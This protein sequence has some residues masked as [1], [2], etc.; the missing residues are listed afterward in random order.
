MAQT[1]QLSERAEVAL[2]KLL[3]HCR[4]KEWAGYDPYDALNSRMLAALPV[5]DSRIPRLAL[6]Q[7]LKRS[8][9]NLRPLLRVPKT[10]NPK[11]L[12]L[13]LSSLLQVSSIDA[14]WQETIYWMINRLQELR[15]PGV[16]YCCWGYS[17][18]WQTRTI[19]VPASAPN[20]VCTTFVANA[21]LDAYE[22]GAS[23]SCV[24]MALSAGEYLLEQL[25][26]TGEKSVAG[27]AYPLPSRRAQVHNANFLASALLCR[28][29][30]HTGE[31][32]F[33][34]PALRVAR[35]SA[36]KQNTDGSWKYGEDPKAQWID[37]FHTGYNLCALRSIGKDLGTAEFESSVQR[38]FEFYRNHFFREDGATRY[39]HNRTYPIDIHCVAQSIVT[40]ATL[41]DLDSGNL[42][43]AHRVLDWALDHLYDQRGFFY[44]R[45]LRL[46]T[47]KTSYMR[48]SQAWM[49]Y[50]MTALLSESH[51]EKQITKVAPVAAC[52]KVC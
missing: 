50:A 9:L 11:A 51:S 1:S 45:A 12:A 29:F 21:L 8:P 40:L 26:W 22:H 28:L 17:F 5:L 13:F 37:N 39:F 18:P 3:A 33:I 49:L 7:A 32:K 47:I 20:L 27:F 30:K 41:R 42:P 23:S 4:S 19:I 15:S 52:M 6:T 35:C 10:Q 24:E 25:Y 14:S 36:E 48:W 34:E 16:S 44:Y 46:L 38:G 2:L 43:L 31:D